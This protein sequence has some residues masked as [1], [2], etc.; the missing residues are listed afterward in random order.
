MESHLLTATL[1]STVEDLHTPPIISPPRSKTPPPA[2]GKRG[3]DANGHTNGHVR[4]ASEA[5]DPDMLSRALKD[6]EEAGRQRDRTPGGSPS[7]KRQRVYGDRSVE[8]PYL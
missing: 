1:T 2:T 4:A 5:I 7:R 3:H 8:I 6:F